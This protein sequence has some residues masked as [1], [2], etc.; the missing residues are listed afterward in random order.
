MGEK[1]SNNTQTIA[2]KS[3]CACERIA[4]LTSNCTWNSF[5]KTQDTEE[6]ECREGC[7][8]WGNEGWGLQEREGEGDDAHRGSYKSVQCMYDEII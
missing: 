5:T 7:R 1:C 3:V 8:F 2:L 6:E 4:V